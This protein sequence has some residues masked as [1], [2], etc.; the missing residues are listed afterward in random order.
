LETT[1]S[2]SDAAEIDVLRKKSDATL[3]RVDALERELAV[4]QARIP[5]IER[6]V[7]MI[8]GEIPGLSASAQMLGNP[9]CPICEVP[10]DRAL[11]DGCKLSHKLPNPDQI[12]ARWEK[13]KQLLADESERLKHDQGEQGRIARDLTPARELAARLREQLRAAERLRDSRS[14]AWHRT[15]SVLDE[16]SRLD[17]LLAAQEQAQSTAD[18]LADSIKHERE[19]TGAFRD[20]QA[21]VFRRLSRV[22]DAIVRELVGRTAKGNLSLDGKGLRLSVEMGG[23]RSTAA[24]DS[25][26][27]LAFDLA[28]LCMS[29]EGATHL[30]AFL[31][32]DSP[33]EADLGL[34]VY[35]QIFRLALNLEQLG[36]EP[37]FQY[38]LTTTTRPPHD[39]VKEPWLVDTLYGSPAAGRLLKRDL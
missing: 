33:R 8:A 39:L 9:V 30:P 26:K 1:D 28:V 21:E 18:G 12:R 11:A 16:V 10:I 13:T 29:I 2:A 17:D 19:R 25:L 5:E 6:L 23:E 36:R 38:V 31:V 37:L 15:R 3:G 4:V 24:I 35:H 20:A 22:F 32:H 34:S 7:S 14:D 27:V